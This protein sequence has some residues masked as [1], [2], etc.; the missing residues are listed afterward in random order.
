MAMT[1]DYTTQSLM[2]EPGRHRRQLAALPD[3][4]AE[5]AG[6]IAGWGIHDFVARPF[7]GIAIPADRAGEIH[8]RPA[9]ALLDR[10]LSLDARALAEERAFDRRLLIRC[11]HFALLHVAAL[12]AK[13][14]AAR[15]RVGFSAYLNPPHFEDHW[16]TEYWN[17]DK[18]RWVL[19]DPQIDAVWRERLTGGDDPTDL[20]RDRFVVAADAWA[21]VRDGADPRRFGIGPEL[22]GLWFVASSLIRDLA[23]LNKVELLPWD[24]WGAQPAPDV[25][26]ADIDMAL[27]DAI[28]AAT[29]DPNGAPE[30]WAALYDGDPRLEAGA[31]V[32]NA[33]LMRMEP[34]AHGVVQAKASA[35]AADSPARA[36]SSALPR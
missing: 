20:A 21:M 18:K 19:V 31:T 24:V 2:S 15:M 10:L 25:T 35:S 1:I 14:I 8:I 7:Y 23:A 4:P 28:A 5:L 36:P 26:E 30:T 3:D 6:I 13:G 29:A 33:I 34:V 9:E 32:F 27:F 17:T 16:I 11:R 12:R 22:R